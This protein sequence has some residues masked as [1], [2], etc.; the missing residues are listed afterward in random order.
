[1]IDVLIYFR[2]WT[3]LLTFYQVLLNSFDPGCLV[4][5]IVLAVRHWFT[6]FE[7]IHRLVGLLF[8]GRYWTHWL[9]WRAIKNLNLAWDT[10]LQQIFVDWKRHVISGT[11]L[12][13]HRTKTFVV[14]LKGVE[15]DF[16]LLNWLS[17]SFNVSSFIWFT[18]CCS[19]ISWWNF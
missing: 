4:H 15:L 17:P 19:F 3:I 9:I 12:V 2:S 10:E 18:T 8:L 1:M 5:S 14:I 11:T 6:L 13:T 16:L 7:C